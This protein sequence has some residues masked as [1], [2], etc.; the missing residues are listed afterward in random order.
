MQ[1]E[2]K[3]KRCG[4]ILI[5]KL[6]GNRR[7][8]CSVKCRAKYWEEHNQERIKFICEHC[9]KEFGRPRRVNAKGKGIRFCSVSCANKVNTKLLIKEKTRRGEVGYISIRKPEHPNNYH[10]RVREHILIMEKMIGRYLRKGEL[11]HHINYLEDDN[12]EENLFLCNTY[13]EHDK[14]HRKSRFLIKEFIR[15]RGLEKELT[16]YMVE[17]CPDLRGN[18]AWKVGRM[19]DGDI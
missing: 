9:G 14:V 8:F 16:D 18:K 2:N 13:K 15:E 4:K 12:R 17:N 10:G 19:V 3:C 5:F 7:K 1:P 11:I 6:R